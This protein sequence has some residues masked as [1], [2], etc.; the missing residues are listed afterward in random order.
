MN[1]QDPIST[2]CPL[3]LAMRLKAGD[4]IINHLLYETYPNVPK[5]N[6]KDRNDIIMSPMFLAI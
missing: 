6:H 5:I 3:Y 1:V 2:V 4:A